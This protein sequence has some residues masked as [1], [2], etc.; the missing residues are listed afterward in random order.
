[1]SQSKKTTVWAPQVLLKVFKFK[2]EV[3]VSSRRKSRIRL[4][5]LPSYIPFRNHFY[6]FIH[7]PYSYPHYILPYIHHIHR[8]THM[9]I[10]IWLY[11]PFLWICGLTLQYMFASMYELSPHLWALHKPIS[12]RVR[13]RRHNATMSNAKNTTYLERREKAYTINALVRIQKYHK[14]ETWEGHI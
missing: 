9:H 4:S 1:M 8:S 12:Y 14:E 6:L 2:R 5:P 7:T 10:L 13:E 11:D 3:Y